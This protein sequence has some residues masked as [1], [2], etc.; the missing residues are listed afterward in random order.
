MYGHGRADYVDTKLLDPRGQSVRPI[1]SV[2]F[3]PNVTG[4]RI[5]KVPRI[6]VAFA[7][8]C[9]FSVDGTALAVIQAPNQEPRAIELDGKFPAGQY[10][11]M[12]EILVN[13][14]AMKRA[15]REN[16]GDGRRRELAHEL[17]NKHR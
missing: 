16:S 9:R 4:W 13:N 12:A 6:R 1:G 17:I 8:K 7:G 2:A 3:V 11:V 14:N 5:S 15:D 10:T